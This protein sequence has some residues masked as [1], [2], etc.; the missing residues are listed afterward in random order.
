[1]IEDQNF[2]ICIDLDGTLVREETL[3]V[4][5]KKLWEKSWVG[6]LHVA[7]TF[8]FKGR[9]AF[10]RVLAQKVMLDPAKLSYHPELLKDLER[11]SQEGKTLVL[12]TGA[13][14]LVAKKIANYLGFFKLVIASQGTQNV[15]GIIKA[16]ILANTFGPG[17]FIYA[18]NS[19]KDIP[20]W[21][22]AAHIVIVNAPSRL[23]AAVKKKKGR[24]KRLKTYE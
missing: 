4:L 19:W 23:V 24:K 2:P 18:G 12:A 21:D 13:D 17:R 16:T 10:K 11:L 3:W 15:V 5:L 9:A 8:C 14:L 20:V 1:M 7:F 22:Q 6:V